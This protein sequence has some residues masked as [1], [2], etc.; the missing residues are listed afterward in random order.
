[1]KKLLPAQKE[2]WYSDDTF[3]NPPY[4]LSGAY[5]EKNYHIGMHMHDFY[6]ICIVLD[7]NSAHHTDNGITQASKGSIFIIPPGI[8]HGFEKYEKK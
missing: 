1:M 5:E 3:G 7:G 4:M 8:L 6:E 2:K